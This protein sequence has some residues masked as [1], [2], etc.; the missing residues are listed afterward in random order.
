MHLPAALPDNGLESK[1]TSYLFLLLVIRPL[2]MLEIS[3]SALFNCVAPW[4][5]VH[6]LV[7]SSSSFG[8]QT[9][10][11]TTGILNYANS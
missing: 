4:A 2:N 6:I 7:S 11:Q 9:N 1:E 5:E 8:K 3:D 10:K